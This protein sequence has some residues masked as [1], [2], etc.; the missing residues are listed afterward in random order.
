MVIIN[1]LLR[2]TTVSVPNISSFKTLTY[3]A[4]NSFCLV[5]KIIAN[6]YFSI[7]LDFAR[8]KMEGGQFIKTPERCLDEKLSE[9]RLEPPS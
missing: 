6:K 2:E 4:S 7:N 5:L 3:Y 8:V 9:I 1:E